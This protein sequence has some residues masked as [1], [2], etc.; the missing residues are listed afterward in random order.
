MTQ[1]DHTRKLAAIL[2]ADAVGYSR[3]MESDEHG[4]LAALDAARAVMRKHI[5]SNQGQVVDM[6]GDSVLAVFPLATGAVSAA[7]SIQADLNAAGHAQQEDRRLLFRVGIHSGEIIEKA[8]GTVYGDGV[9]VAARLQALAPAGAIC[10]SDTVRSIVRNKV[11][12]DFEDLGAQKM[13]NIAEPV[14]AYGLRP[15]LIPESTPAAPERSLPLPT[16]PSIAVLPFA[17]LSADREQ[18]Y[19]ADGL[20]EDIIT[21]L[22]RFER[23]FVIARNTTFTYKERSVDVRRVASD[24]G[25]HFVLEGSVRRAG[26]RVRVAAQLIDG[27]SGQHV[28]AER[29]EEVL[30][31]LFELQERLTRQVVCN[32]V[33]QIEAEEL[34]LLGRGQRRFGEV[35]DIAWRALKAIYDAVFTGNATVSAE[36]VRLAEGALARDRTCRLAWSVLSGAHVWR[37]FFGWA[38]DRAREVRTALSAAD[39]LMSLAPNDSRSYF[40]RGRARITAGDFAGGAADVRRAH[41]LNA[42]DAMILFF[43]SWTEAGAGNV[44]LAK[45]RAAEAIRLSPKDRLIGTAHLALAM[46]AFIERDFD[47]LRK[48]AELAIQSHPTAPIR[49]VLMIA[50]AT[51]VGDQQLLRAHL[52]P[53]T[54]FAPDFIPSLFRGNYRPFYKEEHAARLLESLRKVGLGEQGTLRGIW[55]SSSPQAAGPATE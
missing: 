19:L 8:D 54:A 7:L 28:W 1:A 43:L 36:A 18:E 33:P 31:D 13:K 53:L 39:T 37:V 47:D 34:R 21:D 32:L 20:V 30:S 42:N 45:E 17:N 50:Y 6:A 44:E 38:Q 5:D 24:L 25:V 51:E 52:E 10:V 46:V 55:A 26:D 12:V 2:A 11:A 48:W 15:A 49:R 16:R 3:L 9:N 14:R 23:L 22:S 4:T 27:G 40:S 29:Y 35:D 41:E